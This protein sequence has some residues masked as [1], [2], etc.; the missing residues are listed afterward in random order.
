MFS[1]EEAEVVDF[2]VAWFMFFEQ[3][4]DVSC[5]QFGYGVALVFSEPDLGVEVE[6]EFGL[7]VGGE[8]GLVVI[9][10]V[11]E[12][13]GGVPGGGVGGGCHSNA[14]YES[15]SSAMGVVSGHMASGPIKRAATFDQEVRL[16]L[17]AWEAFNSLFHGR[18][19]KATS[20][21]CRCVSNGQVW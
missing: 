19:R 2:L 13:L 18:R 11:L 8:F 1:E 4:E 14:A 12:L 17:F 20:H 6:P 15:A 5:W 16:N 21:K 7:V 9:A 10:G 3:P